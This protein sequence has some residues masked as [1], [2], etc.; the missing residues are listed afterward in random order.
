VLVRERLMAMLSGD[1]VTF[2]AV[3]AAFLA[4]ATLAA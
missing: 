3:P 1:P 4:V 2:V